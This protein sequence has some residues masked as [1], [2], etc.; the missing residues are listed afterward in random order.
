MRNHMDNQNEK[1][2]CTSHGSAFAFLVAG[3]GIGAVFSLFLAP[4]SGADTRQW[5]ATRCLDGINA[6]NVKVRQARVRVHEL[7]DQTQ[8]KG[9][10]TRIRRDPHFRLLS[11]ER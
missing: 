1:T 8:Q 11:E 5:I 2:E 10:C 9:L 7:V 3:L 4:Q 6:A